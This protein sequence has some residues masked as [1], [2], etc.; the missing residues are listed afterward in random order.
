MPRIDNQESGSFSWNE[1]TTKKNVG[2]FT[3][4]AGPQGAVFAISQAR[5]RK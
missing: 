2:R 3:S 4:I 5:P 1:P